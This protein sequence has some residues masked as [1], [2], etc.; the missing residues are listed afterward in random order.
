[1][2]HAPPASAHR[3]VADLLVGHPYA[4][5]V[6]GDLQEEFAAVAERGGWSAA[7][8][9][10]W[11]QV[12]RSFPSL[13]R[14]VRLD[15][16]PALRLMATAT[17]AFGSALALLRI[18]SPTIVHTVGPAGFG[19]EAVYEGAVL[20]TGALA[21]V[22]TVRASAPRAVCGALMLL[23]LALGV[24]AVHVA[25]GAPAEL[26]FRVL[27]V[28]TLMAALCAGALFGIRRGPVHG[29]S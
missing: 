25:S 29:A 20:I 4:E 7:R 5:S 27:K 14:L 17:A 10:Y 28:V 16:R 18:A 22:A 12:A 8:R 23:A 26:G 9:W 13:I 3:V 19:F 2:T 11:R 1:M 24:G 21:G 6:L 15:S